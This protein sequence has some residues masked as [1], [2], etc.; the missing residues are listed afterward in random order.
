MSSFNRSGVEE[1]TCT[2]T[3][4]ELNVRICKTIQIFELFILVFTGQR[5]HENILQFKF[6]TYFTKFDS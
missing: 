4:A 1:D 3:R 2:C 6:F 5:L